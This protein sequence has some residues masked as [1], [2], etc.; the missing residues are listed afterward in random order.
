MN[1]IWFLLAIVLFYFLY[2][3]A[4]SFIIFLPSMPIMG[5]I[6]YLT[7][8]AEKKWAKIAFIPTIILA[9][10]LGT[11]LPCAIFGMGMGITVLNFTDEATYPLIY[12]ILAGFAAFAISAPS[13][14]TSPPGMIISL[15]AY[16]ITITVSKFSIFSEMT[17]DFLM[18]I[19]W[20][21]L[22]L[23]ILIGIV[24][25]IITFL[26]E[27]ITK[28]S[29]NNIK[30]QQESRRRLTIGVYLLSILFIVLGG[31]WVIVFLF[32]PFQEFLRYFIWGAPLL[33][34]GIGMLIRKYW[35][36][37]LSQIV[38]VLNNLQVFIMITILLFRTK[39]FEFNIFRIL[40][41]LFMLFI[42]FIFPMWFLF[43]RS[44]VAQFKNINN[45]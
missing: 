20:V 24:F 34:G 29:E 15:A 25:L 16:I 6:G 12:F 32:Y 43:K 7:K 39:E 18:N 13:R 1:F 41:A 23:L 37:R 36:L 2:W 30:P 38:L 22:V 42:F 44:T 9:F 31:L 5:F 35:A 27:K 26:D 33:I 14:E 3:Y 10:I 4:L 40:I 19:F 45:L 8:N 11:F 28:K 21:A 17:I